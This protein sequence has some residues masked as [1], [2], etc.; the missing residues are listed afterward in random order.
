MARKHNE[1]NAKTSF[2]C[3]AAEAANV[4]IAGT[5]NNW[6]PQSNPMQRTPDGAW[7]IDLELET[8]RY[9]Y[10]FVVDGQW[11]CEPGREDKTGCPQCVRDGNEMKCADCVPN[12]FGTMNRVIEVSAGRNM[13]ARAV[14]SA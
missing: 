4:F 3:H 9:E 10:K 1:M 13:K 12:G 2:V 14:T 6:D 11:C 7:R 8:G 5:F